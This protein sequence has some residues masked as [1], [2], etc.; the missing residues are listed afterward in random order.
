M[1]QYRRQYRQVES[2]LE[3]RQDT[4]DHVADQRNNGA[5]REF[6]KRSQVDQDAPSASMP[7]PPLVA[8]L[9]T[10]LRANG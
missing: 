3:E 9:F 5:D 2:D 4:D 7:R 6:R 10:D 8:V 1:T